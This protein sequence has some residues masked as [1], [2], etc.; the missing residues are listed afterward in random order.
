MTYQRN[1]TPEPLA[2]SALSI[3]EEHLAAMPDWAPE[4]EVHR[5]W[6]EKL[7]RDAW[8][9]ATE[10]AAKEEREEIRQLAVTKTAMFPGDS[11][12]TRGYALAKNDFVAAIDAR[13]AAAIRGT[14]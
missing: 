12:Y 8:D 13:A 5:P 14:K 2:S 11:D 7:L 6:V 9:A 4:F 10:R 3:F 1:E